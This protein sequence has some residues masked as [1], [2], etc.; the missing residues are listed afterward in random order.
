MENF[1]HVFS[2]MCVLSIQT[3]HTLTK[4]N[5]K[6]IILAC[7]LEGHKQLDCPSPRATRQQWLLEETKDQPIF[8]FLYF[9]S[10][11][12]ICSSIIH[13]IIPYK[14]P[15]IHHSK[16]PE[17]KCV[18]I[19]TPR[20]FRKIPPIITSRPLCSS[21]KIVMSCRYEQEENNIQNIQ[22]C[23][24]SDL[25]KEAWVSA[26]LPSNCTV[27]LI[28]FNKQPSQTIVYFKI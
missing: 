22:P 6:E 16:L 2:A 20:S 23:L 21:L 8:F 5:D 10:N 17:G 13:K 14:A 19:E 27:S 18:T 1:Y 25:Y 15:P 9:S 28:L 7:A 3:V 4:E 11:C 24:L 26:L 12:I